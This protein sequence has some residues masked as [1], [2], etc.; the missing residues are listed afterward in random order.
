MYVFD[1]ENLFARYSYVGTR[2]QDT[3]GLCCRLSCEFRS[4]VDAKIILLWKG[5]SICAWCVEAQCI[6]LGERFIGLG[7]S[8]IRF[9]LYRRHLLLE[10]VKSR[11]APRPF[12][13]G[14][15]AVSCARCLGLICWRLIRFFF[16]NNKNL[17]SSPSQTKQNSWS[18]TLILTHTVRPYGY[19]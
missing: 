6:I 4:T 8:I 3:R 14:S 2:V 9:T 11:A 5:I 17:I 10:S 19:G 1:G 7:G 12:L 15:I 16:H 13:L 18:S